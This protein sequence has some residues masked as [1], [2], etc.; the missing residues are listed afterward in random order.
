MIFFL[1]NS[2][3]ACLAPKTTEEPNDSGETTPITS[4]DTVSC[5]DVQQ[6]VASGDIDVSEGATPVVVTLANV[7]IVSGLTADGKGFYVQDEGGGE[8]SG[9]Y[10]YA[11]TMSGDFNPLVGDKVNITGT[12]SEFYDSTQVKVS[13]SESIQTVGESDVAVTDVS[14]VTDWEVYESVLIGLAD[15]TVVS[16]VNNYGEVQL[17]EGLMMD[18]VFFNFSTEYGASYSR[19]VGVVPYSYGEFK[20]APRSGDDFEGYVAGE[21]PQAQ[22]VA[23]VQSGNIQGPASFEG[24]VVTAVGDEGFWIQDAG[25]GEWSGMYVYTVQS[26]DAITVQVGDVVDVTGSITEY[27]DCTQVSV[28]NATDVEVTSSATPTA[29]TL[30]ATPSDWETYEGVLVTLSNVEIGADADYGQFATNYGDLLTDDEL[31][32]YSFSTGDN[33]A[34]MTGVIHY[35]YG[36]Y[37]ILPR[38]GS[39]LGDTTG[40][41]TSGG[42][43]GGTTGGS[44]S[45]GTTGGGTTP[46][47]ATITDI[48][49]GSISTGDMVEISNVVVTGVS[50]NQRQVFVQE[51][52][53]TEN[54][55]IMIYFGT[56][57]ALSVSEGDIVTVSGTIA[58]FTSS[59]SSR[60]N[61]ELASAS[62]L[63]VIGSGSVTAVE[64]SSDPSDWEL[65]EGMLVTITSATVSSG[66]DNYGV[67]EISEY[68]ISLD[69]T[70]Y[71][72]TSDVSSGTTYTSITGIVD[73]YYGYTILP[74]GNSDIQ[75]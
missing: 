55:G 14:G 26:D 7:V 4:G 46:T 17:S 44:T 43:T 28:Q 59:G 73:D 16:E 60:T 47:A 64:I 70:L 75:Q 12:V 36:E 29:T 23:A 35:T 30:S 48:Q 15:Q 24:V 38:D 50:S 45:G 65:Y 25:G 67:S 20:I 54:V 42:T 40:G 32:S 41:S 74:R 2:F 19:V 3:L 51:Q 58:E 66:A 11:E 56:D 57:N 5:A 62:D 13:T 1:C 31:F 34:S 8:W 22:T 68:S 61:I 52:S 49:T 72:Y 21:G 9:M 69:S 10:I 33:I 53:G 6:R 71:D 27:Y 18:N 37:K 39:D 63:Q